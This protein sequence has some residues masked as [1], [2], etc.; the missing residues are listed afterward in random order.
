M[1]VDFNSYILMA[2]PIIKSIVWLVL[3]LGLTVGLG[4]YLFVIRRRKTWNVNIW[5]QKADG[6]LHL[7]GKDI[8]LEKKINKGMS[9]GAEF[10]KELQRLTRRL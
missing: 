10:K 6:L 1:A 5:E 4:Y 7:V 2:M 3:G 9:G 8:L